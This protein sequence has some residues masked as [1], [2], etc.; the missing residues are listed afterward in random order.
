MDHSAP[1]AAVFFIEA[2]GQYLFYTVD[3]R[4]HGSKR[5]LLER[6]LAN[7]ISKA[8]CLVKEGSMIGREEGRYQDEDSVEQAIYD[9]IADQQSYIFVF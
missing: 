8:D 4:G 1:D 6:L 7:P 2:D 9:V 5:V 3:F